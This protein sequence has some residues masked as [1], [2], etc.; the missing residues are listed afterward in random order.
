MSF[1][2]S[3][4]LY[5]FSFYILYSSLFYG[6]INSQRFEKDLYISDGYHITQTITSN[7]DS[8]FCVL[9][10][11]V[12]PSN[13]NTISLSRLDKFGNLLW[14]NRYNVLTDSF[15]SGSALINTFDNGFII[16][17]GYGKN[18]TSSGSA[19][20][21]LIIKTDSLGNIMWSKSYPLTTGDIVS[22]K[23]LSDSS[24]IL[25]LDYWA[26][27]NPMTILQKVDRNGNILW[28]K[29]TLHNW[30]LLEK[31]NKN[32]QIFGGG[33]SLYIKEFDKNGNDLWEKKYINSKWYYNSCKM[34]AN[35]LGET[36]IFSDLMDS[37]GAIDIAAHILKVDNYGNI[38]FSNFYDVGPWLSSYEYYGEFTKDCGII[39]NTGLRINNMEKQGILKLTTNGILQWLRV[40]TS[41]TFAEAKYVINT[42]DFGYI[43][44]GEAKYG[45]TPI[46]S[47]I[48]K[49]DI[50]GKTAC[51]IDS[52]VS[53]T[54]TP[55]PLIVDSTMHPTF[56]TTVT[57]NNIS[58]LQFVNNAN[59]VSHCS[60]V[61]RLDTPKTCVLDVT[62]N[63]L[64]TESEFFV[65][66]VFTPNNDNINDLFKV[67][68]TNYSDFKIDI[69][70]RW[71]EEIFEST[72]PLISWNGKIKNTQENADDG[73]YYYIITI[74]D[75]SNSEKKYKG[76]LTL[77]R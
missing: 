62:T 17:G 39:V 72:S 53:V 68:L 42:L 6:Q 18:L 30:D 51:D 56:F 77:I 67:N 11:L 55:N 8:T 63:N 19:S 71:G 59:I 52:L 37:L 29:K 58:V 21:P 43:S 25:I 57:N 41:N 74:L 46:H 26:G 36:A 64:P 10:G 12:L 50:N 14:S 73:T 13:F 54:T 23:E 15:N 69:F 40:F 60:D 7:K 66:N 35:N 49:T 4:T 5:I 38:I 32:L 16:A 45:L 28:S 44:L 2:R 3:N 31:P 9:G 24:L 65:P 27:A 48:I 34:D 61:I 75:T 76:F 70:N 47:R 22:I 20:Y 1:F 33:S